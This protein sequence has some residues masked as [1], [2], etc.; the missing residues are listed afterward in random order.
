[1]TNTP[2]AL[3][4]LDMPV[5]DSPVARR[6]L[7]LIVEREPTFLVNHS[8]RSYAWA[9]ALAPT[10]RLEFDPEVLYVAALLH[11]IGLVPALDAGGC[12][13]L[14]GAEYA[15]RVALEAGLAVEP[16]RAVR[17][18]IALHMAAVVPAEVRSESFLLSDS[19]GVDVRGRRLRDIPA[20][21]VP[22]V[23]EAFPRLQFK[24]EFS[25]LFADQAER[26][27]G[28]RVA[29]MVAAGVLSQIA[30]APFDE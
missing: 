20:T 9:V 17:E 19:T 5:P 25:R 18:A 6:A 1:L 16:A 14:E 22:R 23:L 30:N 26:K 15:E 8:I 7:E 29:E 24:R 13:E 10:D 28:C 21:L 4:A 3:R 27:P 2:T 12:F 11:D